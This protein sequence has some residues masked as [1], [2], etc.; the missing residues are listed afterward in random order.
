MIFPRSKPNL[1]QEHKHYSVLLYY[2]LDVSG[3][4]F[5]ESK[6]VL[7]GFIKLIKFLTSLQ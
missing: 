3:I 5:S 2:T 7:M 1:V 4:D 6:Y